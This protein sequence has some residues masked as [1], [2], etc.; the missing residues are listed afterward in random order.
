MKSN[1]IHVFVVTFDQFN[2]SFFYLANFKRLNDNV[3]WFPQKY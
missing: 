2:A 3:S 1:I